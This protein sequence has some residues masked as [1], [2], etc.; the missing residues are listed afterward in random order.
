MLCLVVK[1]ARFLYR[2]YAHFMEKA[3]VQLGNGFPHD[4]AAYVRHVCAVVDRDGPS[5][6]LFC[7]LCY[8]FGSVGHVIPHTGSN[9]FSHCL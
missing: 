5:L 7:M 2:V 9:W 3:L 8:V 1:S 4:S 6:I